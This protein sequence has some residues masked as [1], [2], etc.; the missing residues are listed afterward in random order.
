MTILIPTGAVLSVTLDKVHME[1]RHY[2][3]C[4]CNPNTSSICDLLKYPPVLSY[5]Q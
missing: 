1:K 5:V 2:C 4:H 3:L